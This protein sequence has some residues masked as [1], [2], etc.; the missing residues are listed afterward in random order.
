ML[1]IK[2][3]WMLIKTRGSLMSTSAREI[4]S[5]TPAILKKDQVLAMIFIATSSLSITT[6]LQTTSSSTSNRSAK[7]TLTLQRY[8]LITT[9]SLMQC[10]V[11]LT[12]ALPR[13]NTKNWQWMLVRGRQSLWWTTRRISISLAVLP[14]KTSSSEETMVCCKTQPPTRSKRQR[15]SAKS[16][17]PQQKMNG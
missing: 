10:I 12:A 1:G 17:P 8:K 16:T 14:L 7:P 11:Q 4:T 6:R 13:L 5:F 3:T 9:N 15:N 2:K